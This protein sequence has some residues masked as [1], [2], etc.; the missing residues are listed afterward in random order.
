MQ[1]LAGDDEEGEAEQ[2]EADPDQ[3]NQSA[4]DNIEEPAPVIPQ[5]ITTQPA[6]Q[7]E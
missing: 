1:E 2:D 7:F 5:V 4:D 6:A 3:Q